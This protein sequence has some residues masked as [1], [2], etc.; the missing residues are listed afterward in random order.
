MNSSNRFLLFLKKVWSWI[1][2]YPILVSIA[3]AAPI[4]ISTLNYFFSGEY[5][6]ENLYFEGNLFKAEAESFEL[7]SIK[8]L[9]RIVDISSYGNYQG[10]TCYHN[11]Y[12]L[13]SNNFECIIIYDLD[14]MK[15]AHTIYTGQTN[16]NYHCNTCFF[17]PDFYSAEDKFPLLYISMENVNQT[18]GF[19]I[20]QKAGVYCIEEVQKISLK[21]NSTN[22]LYY[23]NS[24]YDYEYNLLFYSGYTKNSYMR[25][26]DSQLVYYSFP[27][28]DYRRR[29]VEIDVESY[30]DTFTLPSET[31]TQGGFISEGY[32][33]QTFSFHK[34][35]DP[36]R[37]PKMRVVDTR[38]GVLVKDYQDIGALG[39]YE[40]Y[41][42]VAVSD[43]NRL[44]AFGTTTNTL[45]EF[46]YESNY[47]EPN[48]DW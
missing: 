28:P 45:Y 26:S 29:H 38:N 4:T 14:T 22:R 32:L 13:C 23:P 39:Y 7:K 9:K 48:L 42:N 40:E 27:M 21:F 16:T 34:K 15:V 41:E 46:E 35:D 47:V 43:K 31:A 2:K 5:F 19:R 37:A 18:I 20:Y 44:I 36:D 17:S 1:V 8:R 33:Y 6:F 12:L 24:Y 11:Y 3:F 25:S 30:F 10:G